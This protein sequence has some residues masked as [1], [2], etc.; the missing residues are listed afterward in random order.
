MF[1]RNGTTWTEQARLAADDGAAEDLFGN[2]VALVG[3]TALVGATYGDGNAIRS[4][5]AYV[6]LRSGTV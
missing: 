4:G 1:V 5:S 2:S 6:F 3:D